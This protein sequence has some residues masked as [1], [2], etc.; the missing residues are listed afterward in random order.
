MKKI[1]GIVNYTDIFVR[2]T[3]VTAMALCVS[4]CAASQAIGR[5]KPQHLNIFGHDV[6]GQN[7]PSYI[8]AYRDTNKPYNPYN[9][10]SDEEKK[11]LLEKYKKWKALPPSEKNKLRKRMNQWRNL[12][13]KDKQKYRNRFEQWQNLSPQERKR[14]QRHLNNWNSLTPQEKERL[15]QEFQK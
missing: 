11:A 9:N 15:R 4:L 14:Y 10:L 6:S 8:I 5:S 13:P 3:L 2:W 7:I 1:S 12:S